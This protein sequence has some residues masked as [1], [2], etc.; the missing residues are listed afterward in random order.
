MISQSKKKLI[1]WLKNIVKQTLRE[2][3]YTPSYFPYDKTKNE[4]VIK[5]SKTEYPVCGLGL[6]IP[7]KDLRSGYP[8]DNPEYINSGLYD[9]KNMLELLADSGFAIEAEN[10]ILDFGCSTGRMIRHLK[11]YS[12]KSEIWGVDVSSDFI[13]WCNKYLNPP[14]HFATTTLNPHLP[15]EDKYFDL[16]YSGSVFSHIDNFAET[17]LLELKRILSDTGRLYIT[18]HDNNTIGIF[19]KNK[20]IP[21][22][23]FSFENPMFENAVKDFNL[24]SIN[25]HKTPQVFLDLDYFKKLVKPVFD[26]VTVKPEAYGYQTGILLKRKNY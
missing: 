22:S 5:K 24:I 18:I 17:W 4:F 14:F 16:I 7:D 25:R 26:I 13:Y 19:E 23:K 15:F 3:G 12:D 20:N 1:S 21:L 9:V 8:A 10:R 6:S 11:P 2:N